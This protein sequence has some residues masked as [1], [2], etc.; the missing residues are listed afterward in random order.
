M[1]NK[2][3]SYSNNAN[4]YARAKLCERRGTMNEKAKEIRRQYMREW[5]KRNRDKT[6][7]AQRRYWEKQAAQAEARQAARDRE[8]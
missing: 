1:H 6:R 2:C 7:A 8:S 4:R 3:N 5:A